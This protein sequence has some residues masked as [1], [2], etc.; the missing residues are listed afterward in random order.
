MVLPSLPDIVA[1]FGLSGFEPIIILVII[2]VLLL[3]GP[4]KIPELARG[5][6]RA[7]GEFRRGRARVEREIQEE[8]AE[9]RSERPIQTVVEISPR[10]VEAA[11]E[12]DIEVLGRK[13]R[14]LKRAIIA[15]LEKVTKSKLKAVA[16]ALDLDYE[17]LDADQL[18][19]SISE[20]LG[21]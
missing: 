1:Q 10:V 6:G 8:L 14:D 3:L 7:L 9:A 19:D 20:A 15:S 13:E 4:K 18:K 12:L 16:R 11:Q 2:A 17:G 21:I 5:I